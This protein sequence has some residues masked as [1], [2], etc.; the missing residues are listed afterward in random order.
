M[1]RIPRAVS[2][3]K[4]KH[5]HNKPTLPAPPSIQGE[6]S[7]PER[8]KHHVLSIL[9]GWVFVSIL[10]PVG[11]LWAISIRWVK[12][13]EPNLVAAVATVQPRLDCQV[14][15]VRFDTVY[16]FFQEPPP[17]IF[18]NLIPLYGSVLQIN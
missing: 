9:A 18:R 11:T 16:R 7:V 8:K 5:K 4:R 1:I 10:L 12:S 2:M 6:V 13:R 14:E 15:T 3:A 17:C